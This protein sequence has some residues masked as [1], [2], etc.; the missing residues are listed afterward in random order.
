MSRVTLS[1]SK[2]SLPMEELRQ[3]DQ[4]TW[5]TIKDRFV[6]FIFDIGPDVI[7]SVILL[8]VGVLLIRLVSRL[9]RKS[10]RKYSVEPSLATFIESLAKFL[11]YATLIVTVGTTLGIKTSSFVAI[12]GAAGIA[13]GLALQGSLANFAGGVLILMF[14][15]FKVGDLIFV[16]GNLGIVI[17]IDILYTRLRTFDNRI[18]T[19]PNGNVANSDVD[20]RSMERTRRLDFKLKFDYSADLRE[21]R[22]VIV[23][24]LK[25]HPKALPFPAPDIWLDEIGE[26][27][28][29]VIARC[30]VHTEDFWPTYWEQMEAIKEVLQRKNISFPIP[31]QQVNWPKEMVNDE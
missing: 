31:K 21:I 8:F 26:Y 9:L 6:D 11:L 15:P 30:W 28:L 29:K 5:Q 14:K 24:A 22:E 25:K 4:D 7:L 12:I 23:S 3:L 20:N 19:M 16:N 17:E 18:I 1:D 2:T 13:I 10:F 27:D